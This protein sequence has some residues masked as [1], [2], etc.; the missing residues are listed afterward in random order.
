MGI[1]AQSSQNNRQQINSL[2]FYLALPDV[3]ALVL[4]AQ[5]FQP[6]F[7]EMNHS[8]DVVL[9]RHVLAHGRDLDGLGEVL[10]DFRA[11][12][13]DVLKQL[14]QRRLNSDLLALHLQIV[15]AVRGVGGSSLAL[16]RPVHV[17]VDHG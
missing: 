2:P 5:A 12:R 16:L 10:R 9:V 17:R 6:V 11:I 3:E 4:D 15:V 13:I 1:R 7:G 8:D 14:Q